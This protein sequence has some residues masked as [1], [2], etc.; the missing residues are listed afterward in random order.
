[1]KRLR[2]SDLSLYITS[3][4]RKI[5]PILAICQTEPDGTIVAR[6]PGLGLLVEGAGETDESALLELAHIVVDQKDRLRA[7][8]LDRLV[9]NAL[10]LRLTLDRYIP[11][12]A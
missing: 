11:D 9:G 4:P 10:F 6:A 7:I 12:P 2:E 1:M 5:R 3:L 8:P